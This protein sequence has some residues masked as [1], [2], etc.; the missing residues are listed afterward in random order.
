VTDLAVDVILAAGTVFL[1]GAVSPGPSLMVVL[2]NTLLGGRKQGV[3]CA[4]GH[5]LGFGIYAGTAV[6]GL[7]V[8]LEQAPQVFLT[9]Q[10]IGVGLLGWYGWQMWHVDEGVLFE[11]HAPSARQGFAEGFAIAFFNP[12]IALFLVAVL[13]SVLEEGMSLAS[14]LAVGGL[15]MAIDAVWY[16][17]VA[18]LLSGTARIDVL[19]RHALLLHRITA[20][21]LWGFGFSVL[22]SL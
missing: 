12:K 9:L 8:L 5:G 4:L 7:I 3:M 15:G 14:K 19:K 6:F 17:I 21:V 10:L 16:V 1:L 18:T 2:R 20:A 13:A 11:D 22:W